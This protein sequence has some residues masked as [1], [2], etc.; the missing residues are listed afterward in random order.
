[1]RGEMPT[2]TP[3]EDA[4]DHLLA[5]APSGRTVE[6]V[7]IADALDRVLAADIVAPLSIPPWDCSAM[8]GFAFARDTLGTADE[9][10]LPVVQRIAAGSVGTRLAPGGAAQIF[11]G[12]PIPPGADTV[13]PQ[14]DCS[15]AD[16]TVTIHHAPPLG[17]NV[18]RAG[19]DIR[20][21]AIVLRQ[22]AVLRAG[23]LGLAASLGLVELPVYRRLKT[24]VFF[25]GDELVRPGEPLG[26][27]KIYR[28]NDCTLRA[29]LMRSGCQV[30]D[31]GHVPDCPDLTAG[32]LDDAGHRADVVISTGGASVGEEDHVR[33]ALERVGRLE[34]WRLNL[35]PGKP[36]IYGRVH[37]TPFIGLP[38]NPVAVFITFLLVVRPFLQRLQGATVTRPAEFPVRAGFDWP[39]PNKR[40]EFLRAR[41]VDGDD[42]RPEVAIHPNQGSGALGSTAWA[43]GLVDIPGSQAVRRG[44]TVGFLPFAGLLG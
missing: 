24:A 44:E 18:R 4:L 25:T 10:T 19:E 1:M 32:V 3:L 23:A 15:A 30:I 17:R 20:K 13:V 22:G 9:V 43:D 41:L 16:G 33:H 6:R 26:A 27:G 12:G 34:L 31:L 35:K 5:S 11:T 21:G 14:E 38:G 39:R 7:P 2:L 40:R 42:G 36:L 8:D 28:S 29:L 37:G